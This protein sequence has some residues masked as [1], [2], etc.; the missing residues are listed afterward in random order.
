MNELNE[1]Q[2][3]DVVHHLHQTVD[4]FPSVDSF[5]N[6][7]H[8]WKTSTYFLTDDPADQD[9]EHRFHW[10]LWLELERLLATYGS[11]LRTTFDEWHK[12]G[13][14]PNPQQYF[15][16]H[17]RLLA[18]NRKVDEGRATDQDRDERQHLLERHLPVMEGQPRTS[19]PLSGFPPVDITT[20]FG[21]LFRDT[22][23]EEE[24]EEEDNEERD[25]VTSALQLSNLLDV[26]GIPTV[27]SPIP[28]TPSPAPPPPP[29]PP[30]ERVPP[31]TPTPSTP[32]Q[33]PVP[34][35][36]PTGRVPPGTPS[37]QPDTASIPS[38]PSGSPTPPPTPRG[39]PRDTSYSSAASVEDYRRQLEQDVEALEHELYSP[40]QSQSF[41]TVQSLQEQ[42]AEQEQKLATLTKTKSSPANRRRK[43][44]RRRGSQQEAVS[45]TLREDLG[46]GDH[47]TTTT[48]RT[49]T[50]VRKGRKPVVKRSS[51]SVSAPLSDS[52]SRQMEG[53]GSVQAVIEHLRKLHKRRRK[54]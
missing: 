31:G 52:S 18:L 46:K 42:L 12:K 9:V 30:T 13:L 37:P 24:E 45:A 14:L 28:P 51:H 3:Y 1:E 38:A 53:R 27:L 2:L 26:I 23:P 25:L 49:I 11:T 33:S 15:Q 48:T 29:P 47:R 6:W 7:Y 50:T 44:V 34:P 41:D 5:K 19:S 35:P 39:R 4:S 36:T 16:E 43:S 32:G 20:D 21:D 10:S 40:N 8:Q 22:R 17:Q 54:V